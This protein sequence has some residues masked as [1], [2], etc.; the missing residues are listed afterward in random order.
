MDTIPI[1]RV[2]VALRYQ[3]VFSLF[4][5]LSV[6]LLSECTPEA[7]ITLEAAASVQSDTFVRSVTPLFEALKT[8]TDLLDAK[9][10]IPSLE[11]GF[12]GFQLRIGIGQID[13]TLALIVLTSKAHQWTGKF[14]NISYS[15]TKDSRFLTI[16]TMKERSIAPKRSW[17]YVEQKLMEFHILTLPDREDLNMLP[18]STNDLL[19]TVSYA[20]RSKFRYYSMNEPKYFTS[21]PEAVEMVKI[22]NLLKRQFTL[23]ID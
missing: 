16:H 15:F 4:F 17:H 22:L 13:G 18:T 19:V 3:A 6:T 12:D 2:P 1:R 5:F 8:E 10:G 9:L 23:P 7:G 14:Y 11:N 20:T 21:I